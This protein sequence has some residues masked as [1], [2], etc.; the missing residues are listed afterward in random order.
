M[1]P[2]VSPEMLRALLEYWDRPQNSARN[3]DRHKHLDQFVRSNLPTNG[4]IGRDCLDASA[5]HARTINFAEPNLPRFENENCKRK[6]FPMDTY[7]PTQVL[8]SHMLNLLRLSQR[9]IDCCM[10]GCET[11]NMEFFA[12]ILIPSQNLDELHQI[13]SVLTHE[14]K[15]TVLLDDAQVRFV[16]ASEAICAAL[17]AAYNHLL[18]IAR[19]TYILCKSGLPARSTSL[20]RR[21][22]EV[23]G[24][25]RLCTIAAFEQNVEHAT[26]VL[27][28][29][30]N[31]WLSLRPTHPR[32]G[33]DQ[34]LC[35]HEFA[36][37]RAVDDIGGLFRAVAES[38]VFW[39]DQPSNTLSSQEG[40]ELL[41]MAG[42][43]GTRTCAQKRCTNVIKKVRS[44]CRI[45]RDRQDLIAGPGR[46]VS[47]SH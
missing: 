29:Q 21:C 45:C 31:T 2:Y 1:L 22:E 46:V 44:L 43:R 17:A 6:G 27:K 30:R 8:R 10:K 16:Q 26:A 15:T 33:D 9:T 14:L 20:V 19:E 11:G 4:D 18:E 7:P 36:I 13:I 35:S 12:P 41:L 40:D 23:N 39:L 47:S 28:S 42:K 34:S 38:I 5:H 37:A 3:N 24:W 32:S 25:A